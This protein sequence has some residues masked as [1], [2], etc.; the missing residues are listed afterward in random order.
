[1]EEIIYNATVETNKES[2]F[3]KK[4]IRVFIKTNDKGYMM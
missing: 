1:M 2:V 3:N 4:P